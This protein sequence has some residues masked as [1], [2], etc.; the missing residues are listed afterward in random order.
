M[1]PSIEQLRP[2]LR[3]FDFRNLFVEG[4]GW[5]Q[6]SGQP[7]QAAVDG[8]D[9]PL[10][11]QA[12]KAG[13][14]IYRGGPDSDGGVPPYP[15]RR[16][17]EHQVAKLTFEHLIVFVDAAETTQVSQW[18]KRESG[19]P[20]ACREQ[21]FHAGHGGDPLLQRLRDLTVTLDEEAGLTIGVVA[22]RVRQAMDVE[23]LTKRFYERFKKDWPPS[24]ASSTVS[25]RRATASGTP[26]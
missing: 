4:L 1:S 23:R 11:P 24:R 25:R 10:Q 13:F 22:S 16:K 2:F 17:V 5:N 26:R 7:V 19:K 8:H 14:V 3:S 20:A 21:A 6:Y 12:E 18:V 9:Y 15:V